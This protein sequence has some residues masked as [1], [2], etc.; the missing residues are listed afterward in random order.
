[1]TDVD[2]EYSASLYFNFIKLDHIML[3][4]NPNP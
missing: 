2:I 3:L 1:M 4:F